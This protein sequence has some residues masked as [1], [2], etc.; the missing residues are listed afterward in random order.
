VTRALL[1]P[2]VNWLEAKAEA[3]IVEAAFSAAFLDFSGAARH[4]GVAALAIAGARKV[5]SIGGLNSS[6]GGG[7]GGGSGGSGYAGGSTFTPSAQAQ[8]A[9]N[10][11]I[12]FV[13]PTTGEV[14]N[15]I[16]YYL[17]RNTT[18]NKPIYVPATAGGLS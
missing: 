15:E 13:K 11:T 9:T 10:I 12:Q 6:G 16:S 4:A 8:G 3:E 14:I 5:A 7:G 18:L 2:I 17:Q 1:T